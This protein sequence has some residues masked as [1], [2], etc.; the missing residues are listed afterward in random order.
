MHLGID[1]GAYKISVGKPCGKRQLERP[2]HRWEHTVKMQGF[3]NVYEFHP[4]QNRAQW[5]ALVSTVMNL[6]VQ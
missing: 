4:A 5:W 3:E 2:R 1:K 6:R